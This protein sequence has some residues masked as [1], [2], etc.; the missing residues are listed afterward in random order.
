MTDFKGPKPRRLQLNPPGLQSKPHGLHGEA[1]EKPAAGAGGLSP[2]LAAVA[3]LVPPGTVPVDVGTDHA[4]LPVHLVEAGRCPRVIA[5]EAV[6]GPYSR[7]RMHLRDAGVEPL[8]DLRLADGLA[9]IRE[10]EAGALVIAGLGGPAMVGILSRRLPVAKSIPVWILQPA[11]GSHRIRRFC[12][13]KDFLIIDEDLVE[14]RGRIYEIIVIEPR[15]SAG[16]V[17]AGGSATGGAPAG[18][19]RPGGAPP[20]GEHSFPPYPIYEVSPLLLERGHPLLQPFLEEKINHYRSLLTELKQ[21]NSGSAKKMKK[22]VQTHVHQL[23][24]WRRNILL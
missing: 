17:G 10:G 20:M 2:R 23:E 21:V 6:P 24:E 15:S 7:A 9:G 12:H 4:Q 19:L 13:D 22:Q 1:G 8:V 14:D 18:E 5:V 16:T 3:A 11:S